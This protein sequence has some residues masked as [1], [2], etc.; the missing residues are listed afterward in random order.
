MAR[1]IDD[2]PISPEKLAA[3]ESQIEE[4]YRRYDYDI[5]EFPIEV[6]FNKCTD[7]IEE[8][9]TEWFVPSYQ[10]K[11][12]W[13]DKLQSQFIESLLL[14][15]PIPYLYVSDTGEESLIE[16]V[17]GSQ[18]VRTII[19]FIKNDLK[20]SDM[21]TLT[22]LE[23][24]TFGDFSKP[25]QRRFLRKTLRTIELL[26]MDEDSRRDLF[27]R[28]NTGGVKLSDSEKRYG[29]RDGRFFELVKRLANDPLFHQLCPLSKS[30]SVRREY[31]EL[32]LRF[33]AY[34]NDREKF[35]HNVEKFLDEY[36][37]EMNSSEF[38]YAEYEE[39]FMK[40]MR[41]VDENFD[42]GFRKNERNTS[43]PRIRFEAL[44]VGVLDALNEKPDLKLSSAEWVYD[45]KDHFVELTTSDASNS[46]PKLYARIEYVKNNLLRA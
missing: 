32:V 43:V 33:F 27:N 2:E 12:V 1:K 18:R 30:K 25:S 9:V 10:R 3:A 7:F 21:K 44:A 26:S 36:L 34:A 20:L 29:I 5:R 35:V 14:N 38:N 46:R 31:D 15:L 28:L 23:G 13:P 11:H 4:F 41:F 6:I 22:N 40:V 37:D 17:D 16:I 42:H 8:D 19:R 45:S 39:Q 24:F